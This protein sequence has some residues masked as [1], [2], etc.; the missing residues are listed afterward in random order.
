[1]QQSSDDGK[2]QVS[3]TSGLGEPAE[4]ISPEDATAGDPG[5]E[6]GEAHEG[7][8]GPDVAPHEGSPRASDSPGR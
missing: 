5:D 6:S 1:M 7:E 2:G 8:A 3:E 4:P